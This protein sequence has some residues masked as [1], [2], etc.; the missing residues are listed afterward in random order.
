M[1][2]IIKKF[3][4]F[5]LHTPFCKINNKKIVFDNFGGKGYGCNPK[6]I[7]EEI[8]KEKI[9]C[10]MVWLVNDLN[11]EMPKE[12][13]KVKYGTFKSYIE[14]ATSKVWI[15]NVRSNKGVKKKKNQFY[16]QTWHASMGFK[17]SEKQ[18][19]DSLNPEYVKI[20]KKDGKMTDLMFSDSDFIVNL[21]KENF[22]NG[23]EVLKIGIPRNEILTN[24]D[25]HIKDKVYDY[26]NIDKGK[27]IVIYAPTFRNN[28]NIDV[29]KFDYEK[30][31]E[32]LNKKF[33]SDFVML[34]RL[35]PNFLKYDYMLNYNNKV[36]N[37]TKY[38][39]IQELLAVADIGITD[40]SSIAF[41]MES[42]RKNCFSYL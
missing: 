20:A 8:I 15:D 2:E 22:W 35:H 36:L 39:D 24:D 32:Y 25:K 10:E 7:A 18:I 38:P 1:K 19:E 17:C 13:R 9:N 28:L 40:Y 42:V 3:I 23:G 6:Y 26:F 41:D 21:Y 27:K 4:L 30:C 29:Y 33:N 14:Y 34:L 16:I 11:E 5:L 37:A 31:I 12:I